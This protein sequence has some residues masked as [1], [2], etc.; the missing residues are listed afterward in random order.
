MNHIEPEIPRKC[1]PTQEDQDRTYRKWLLL[2]G[3]WIKDPIAI[4][5][6]QLELI[7]CPDQLLHY[8]ITI[9]VLIFHS[10][11]DRRHQNERDKANKGLVLHAVFAVY[12][13]PI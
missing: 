7:Q 10:H 5:G 2:L 9:H 1:I 3:N 4:N 6:L 13:E 8:S 11:M 12:P